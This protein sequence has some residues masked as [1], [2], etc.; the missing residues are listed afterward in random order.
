MKGR[1]RG[2][3]YSQFN[4]QRIGLAAQGLPAVES[5]VF[6]KAMMLAGLSRQQF[7]FTDGSLSVTGVRMKVSD[8]AG[9]IAG[10]T[11]QVTAARA[12]KA[13][14]ALCGA[15]LLS[16]KGK[17]SFVRVSLWASDQGGA[18]SADAERKRKSRLNQ[19]VDQVRG[20]LAGINGS[21][22]EVDDLL[23][24]VK[25]IA[26]VENKTAGNI[27]R[28]LSAVGEI[29][30]YEG[31]LK[32]CVVPAKPNRTAPAALPPPHESDGPIGHE[33][34]GDIS[35]PH[36]CDMSQSLD[37]IHNHKR[38][39]YASHD[40]DRRAGGYAR[41]HEKSEPPGTSLR[42]A[43]GPRFAENEGGGGSAPGTA[44]ARRPGARWRS[45]GGGGWSRRR[46]GAGSS[47]RR[48]GGLC[49]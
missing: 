8:F 38:D 20:E 31:G 11:P 22:L 18:P 14:E 30:Q 5:A 24:R 47:V 6:F 1:F 27:L 2:H 48:L 46:R 17:G 44:R 39:A 16:C 9:W 36:G 26:R 43:P 10:V 13:I 33:N 12:E 32:V 7:D 41:G 29:V 15:G 23:E 40:H 21:V 45:S 49:G 35:H 28:E 34:E 42:S 37:H 4:H 19:M 3:Y 25:S